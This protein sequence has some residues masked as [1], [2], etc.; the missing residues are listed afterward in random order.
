MPIVVSSE[1]SLVKD[2]DLREKLIDRIDVLDRVKKLFLIPGLEMITAS[3]VAN[4]YEVDYETLRKCIARNKDEIE[5]DGA[6]YMSASDFGR[7]TMSHPKKLL[8][9]KA[10]ITTY[11]YP[12]GLIL[13]VN[14]RGTK[15]FSKRA[16]LRI[17]MLL[18]DSEVAKEVRTQLLYLLKKTPDYCR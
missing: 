7:D 3:Q 11:K 1:L 4:F 6:V 12:N 17:G 18:R 8:G 15:V 9:T 16:V 13:E 10:C 2:M 14:N 5:E